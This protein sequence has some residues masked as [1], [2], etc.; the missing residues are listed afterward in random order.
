MSNLLYW[1]YHFFEFYICVGCVI[2]TLLRFFRR[3][4]KDCFTFFHTVS[5]LMFNFLRLFHQNIWSS[6][7]PLYGYFAFFEIG[8][9]TLFTSIFYVPIMAKIYNNFT[10][11]G[12]YYLLLFSIRSH[13]HCLMFSGCSVRIVELYF[14]ERLLSQ[15]LNKR[16]SWGTVFNSHV[17]KKKSVVV[18][19]NSILNWHGLIFVTL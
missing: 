14:P 8:F 3:N 19:F 2:L 7:N 13:F 16:F 17:K 5:L 15:S 9:W 1:S 4:Q 6:S 10:A 18:K 12:K 11:F